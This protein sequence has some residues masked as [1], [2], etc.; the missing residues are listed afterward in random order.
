MALASESPERGSLGWHLGA[1]ARTPPAP[2]MWVSYVHF[3]ALRSRPPQMR[4]SPSRRSF[5]AHRARE[6][7]GGDLLQFAHTLR[8]KSL[9]S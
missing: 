5:H 3:G 7:R 9:S 1:E 6:A 2:N 4:A 8:T